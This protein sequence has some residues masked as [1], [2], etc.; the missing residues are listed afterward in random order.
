MMRPKPS[1]LE[2][3]CPA[4]INL[5]LRVLGRRSD[6]Y[7]ELDTVYQAIDLHDS[8]SISPASTLSLSCSQQGVP[9]DE[10]N[11]VL[12]AVHLLQREVS[13][14]DLKATFHLEKRIPVGGGLGGGSSN[15]AAALMLGNAHWELGLER[16]ALLAL[17]AELGADVPFFLLGG[18][19]RG[20]DRGDRLTPLESLAEIPLLLGIPPFGVSTEEAFRRLAARLTP[21]TIDDNL[22]LPITYKLPKGKDFQRSVNDLE[23][24]VFDDWPVL[25]QFRDSLLENAAENALMSGSGSTVF[26]TFAHPDTRDLVQT[27]LSAAFPDWTLSACRTVATG[28]CLTKRD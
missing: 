23:Q 16:E 8:L 28:I 20:R 12:R 15:A 6:G 17:A 22:R 26:G 7:H 2:A 14:R 1:T 21:P 11:L 13:G 9:V 5:S 19:A 18:R 24:V 3:A 10:S 4:K 27:K 25:R